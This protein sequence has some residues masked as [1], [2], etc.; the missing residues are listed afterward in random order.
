MLKFFRRIRQNLISEMKVSRYLLYAVGE[1]LLVMIGILLA[2]QVNNWNEH[3]KNLE[4]EK[5]LLINL[6]E[7]LRADSTSFSA[8]M[9]TLQKIDTL[10]SQ[11]YQI[12]VKGSTSIQIE[13]PNY[14]RRLLYYKPMSREN[15]P[16]IASKISNS[17]IREELLT[18][19][20]EI[21][22]MNQIYRELD[23]VIRNRIRIYLGKE[24]L[25]N[26]PGWFESN[27]NFESSEMIKETDLIALSKKSE[28]Q[29]ILFEANAKIMD[30]S[31][32]LSSLIKQNY[33]LMRAIEASFEKS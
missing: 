32:I 33:T 6:V 23:D 21:N 12:G 26:L 7:D 5:V 17:A 4:A 1:I 8:Y 19:M 30:T 28:F 16:L 10:H 2:L 27:K 14:I 11:L 20:Q 3:R 18:Y 15:D 31:Q 24:Q 29:Q 13:N 22:D 25:Y 9:K